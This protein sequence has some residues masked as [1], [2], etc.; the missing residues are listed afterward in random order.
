[1]LELYEN[2][3][4]SCFVG[5]H[6]GKLKAMIKD[7]DHHPATK[8]LPAI[9]QYT[10]SEDYPFRLDI[11]DAEEAVFLH[12][13]CLRLSKLR[14]DRLRMSFIMNVDTCARKM[15]KLWNEGVTISRSG[16]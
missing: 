12:T 8:A 5:A 4:Y 16:E 6:H 9:F 15:V 1:M 10:E 14:T 3:I 11:N 13:L 2:R 7:R